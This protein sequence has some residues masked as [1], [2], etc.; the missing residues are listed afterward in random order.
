MQHL[1]D[2]IFQDRI[3]TCPLGPTKDAVLKEFDKR[4]KTKVNPEPFVLRKS[5]C[6][7]YNTSPL[8]IKK[9]M[10][11]QDNIA[12]NMYSYIQAFSPEATRKRIKA[13]MMSSRLRFV[14][15]SLRK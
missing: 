5:K 14:G 12:E 7:F 3:L 8:D 6:L 15:R 4:T 11:D 2:A 1:G 10:G 9:L 13:K